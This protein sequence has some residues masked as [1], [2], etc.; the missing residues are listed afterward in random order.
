MIT[1]NIFIYRTIKQSNYNKLW[2]CC[3]K[4]NMFFIK[5]GVSKYIYNFRDLKEKGIQY[6]HLHCRYI[7]R[8]ILSS[9][10]P[11][12]N[13]WIRLWIKIYNSAHILSYILHLTIVRYDLMLSVLER[14]QDSEKKPACNRIMR[15]CL[16]RNVTG[17]FRISGEG[18]RWSEFSFI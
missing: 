6:L 7:W 4:L 13:I 18:C 2:N 15:M 12:M 16:L 9:F 14:H 11:N 17:E 3:W 8:L 1:R 10:S 5:N